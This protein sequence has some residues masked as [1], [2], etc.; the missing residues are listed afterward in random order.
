MAE[1]E[2]LYV[3]HLRDGFIKVPRYKRAKKAVSHLREF[4]KRHMKSKEVY[5]SKKVNEFIWSRGIKNPPPRIKVVAVKEEAI[6]KVFLP[7]EWEEMKKSKEKEKKEV[8]KKDEEKIKK[9]DKQEEKKEEDKKKE[10][11]EDK[12]KGVNEEKAEKKEEKS[13]KEKKQ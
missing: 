4:I 6:T 11:K 7:E 9:K 2:R 8:E 13:D 5:I 12:D 1:L 3:V 10:D